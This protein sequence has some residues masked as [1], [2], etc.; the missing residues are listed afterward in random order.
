MA[1]LDLKNAFNEVDQED[2]ATWLLKIVKEV[3]SLHIY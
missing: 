3:S 2:L 1:K